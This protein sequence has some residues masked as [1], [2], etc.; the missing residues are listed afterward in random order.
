MDQPTGTPTTVALA[1][2]SGGARG[3]AHI[4]AIQVLAERGY[5]VVSIAG[6]SMGALVGGLLAVDRL[7][8]YTAWVEGLTQLDVVRLMDPS[9]S[10]PGALRAEK[11]LA[12]VQDLLGDL[13]IEDLPIPYTAVATDL[14]ARREVWFQ[15][16]PLHMAIRASI[17]IPGIITPVVLNGRI[18]VDGGVMNP[19]PVAPTAAVQADLTVAVDLGGE[20]GPA[21]SAP[22]VETAEARPTEEWSERFRRGAATLF[23]RDLW[24]S[25]SRRFAR[26]GDPDG[27]LDGV[28]E[29]GEVDQLLEEVAAEATLDDPEQVFGALPPGLSRF[30]VMNQSLAAMQRV[31]TRYRLAGYPPDVTVTVPRDACRSLE[32]HRAAELIDLGR[33]LCADAL[34][35]AGLADAAVELPVGPVAPDVHP[36][37]PDGEGAEGPHPD[38]EEQR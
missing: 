21:A 38:P 12:R 27:A 37:G 1:L 3:Y 10:A 32:F 6:T 5:R 19:V 15:R 36:H 16:G 17:A 26:T 30:D 4:G 8:D 24:R 23:D 33:T 14:L 11:L 28:L 7:D 34:D 29:D 18:L 31:L 13:R 20:P 22:A 2:G 9:L 25:V 35:A